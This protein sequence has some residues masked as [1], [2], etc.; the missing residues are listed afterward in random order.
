M[1]PVVF[2][3]TLNEIVLK[4]NKYELHYRGA[5]RITQPSFRT[6][7]RLTSAVD[8]P[9]Q[10]RYITRLARPV[11]ACGEVTHISRNTSGATQFTE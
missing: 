2:I 4:L 1:D 5:H 9:Q 6:G 3:M 11:D 10:M 7:L 8:E